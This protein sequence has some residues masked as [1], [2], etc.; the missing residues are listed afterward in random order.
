MQIKSKPTKQYHIYYIYIKNKNKA[1]EYLKYQTPLK[2]HGTHEY[3]I[4]QRPQG[5]LEDSKDR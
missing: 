4:H 3:H 2:R 1:H 5:I